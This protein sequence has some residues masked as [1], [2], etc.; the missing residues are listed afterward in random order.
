[1]K[2]R[3]FLISIFFLLISCEK[4]NDNSVRYDR[5][6]ISELNLKAVDTLEIESG[7]YVLDAYLWRDFQPFC[8]PDGRPLISLN[9][10]INIDSI[11]IPGNI[12]LIKQ[13]VIYNDLVWISVYEDESRPPQPEYMIEKVSREGP[14]WGPD[15]EVDIISIVYNSE[16]NQ[17]YY[18]RLK[19]VH[20]DQ[21]L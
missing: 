2:H 8:P 14:K 9:W 21:T 5:I 11:A 18:L 15:V 1:M 12:D 7:S 17:E 6:L 16:T 20:I 3:L 13:Y 19:D 10:F 4:N